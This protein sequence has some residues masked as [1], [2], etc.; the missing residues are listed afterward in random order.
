MIDPILDFIQR[1]FSKEVCGW[2]HYN[3]YYFAQILK[4]R[5]PKVT[6]LY[7]PIENH[8]VCKY[9]N[10]YYDLYGRHDNLKETPKIWEDYWKED[11]LHYDRIIRDCVI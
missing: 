5:F 8:F 11:Q 4:H 3:C 6:I 2:T 7:L 1:R 9:G 10:Y